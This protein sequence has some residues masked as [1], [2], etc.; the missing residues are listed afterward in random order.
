MTSPSFPAALDALANPGPTTETDDAGFEL[1]IVV[2]RLQNCI[3]AIESKLGIGVGGPPAS[4]AVLRRTAAGA[5]AWGQIQAGDLASTALTAVPQQLYG[6]TLGAPQTI[7][8]ILGISQAYKHLEL[9]IFGRSNVAATA[10]VVTLRFNGDTSAVYH[11]QLLQ[12]QNG[13][14]LPL[15]HPP[16]S[17]SARL[18]SIPG[19]TAGAALAFGI[20]T[21]SIPAYTSTSG[22]QALTSVNYQ[23]QNN[24]S[25]AQA[26]QLLGDFWYGSPAAVTQ[27]DIA[28][29]S[30]QWVAG[31]TISLYGYP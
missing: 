20:L 6:V 30:G 26:L 11:G 29:A 28:L 23:E 2:A 9:R 19:A 21:V 14:T 18:G 3:M 8:Q 15:E 25:G 4:A 22:Y 31:T 13:T 27:L 12:A 7:V 5:S 16:G 24:L 10:D 1:D 17:T